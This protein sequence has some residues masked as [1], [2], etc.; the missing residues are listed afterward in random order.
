M[1]DFCTVSTAATSDSDNG[2]K[3]IS[4]NS[5]VTAQVIVYLNPGTEEDG[6]V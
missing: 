2:R 6:G 1:V 3:V 5:V 4:A